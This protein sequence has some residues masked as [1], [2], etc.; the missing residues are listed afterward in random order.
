MESTRPKPRG[1]SR[2]DALCSV[3]LVCALS[4]FLPVVS[5]AQDA[6]AEAAR[7]EKARKEA[8][9]KKSRHVYTNEDLNKKEILDSE[10]RAEVEA[11][12]KQ[13]APAPSVEPAQP[14]DSD[15]AQP[16]TESLG[17]VA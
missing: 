13:V 11:R 9:A 6:V 3:A 12:K 4:L 14:V 1:P 7:Q 17:E 16:A 2:R 15:K 5:R 8:L 10:D